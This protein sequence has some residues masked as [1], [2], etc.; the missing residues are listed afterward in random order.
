MIKLQAQAYNVFNH[1]QFTGVTTAAVFNASGVQTNA[2]RDRFLR[3][4]A[5]LVKR[6]LKRD[7]AA[8]GLRH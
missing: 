2:D 5:P 6:P 4:C 1:T 7:G 3:I 8:N